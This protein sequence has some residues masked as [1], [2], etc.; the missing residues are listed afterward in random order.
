[1]HYN[2]HNRLHYKKLGFTLIELLVVIAIIAIL[3]AILFPVFSK[4]KATSYKVSC[5]SNLRQVG[6]AFRAYLDDWGGIVPPSADGFIIFNTSSPGAY[7]QN[8][9]GWTEKI[10]KYTSNKMELFK[11]AARK[12]N[13]A[14]S[15][16]GS[17][18]GTAYTRNRAANPARPS[19]LIL[20]FEAPGSGSGDIAARGENKIES[21]NADQTNEGQADGHVYGFNAKF[22]RSDSI[23]NYQWLKP[24][25]KELNDKSLKSSLH[26]QLYFP[27]PHSGH[28]NILFFDG[29]VGAFTDWGTGR[30]TFIP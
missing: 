18:G 3:A 5:T 13:F 1:M 6:V 27:G 16:N 11:C 8:A 7:T 10:Y 9:T 14:Y 25:N 20:I 21:G 28:N 24:N 26:S 15:Y 19:R 4:A 29:H 23:E 17:L 30:M 12:V 2:S 22:N